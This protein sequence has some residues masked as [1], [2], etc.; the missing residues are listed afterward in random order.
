MLKTLQGSREM[1]WKF[2][3]PSKHGRMNMTLVSG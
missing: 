2:S 1:G 3:H